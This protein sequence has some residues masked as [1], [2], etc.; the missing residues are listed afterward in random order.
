MPNMKWWQWLIRLLLVLTIVLI[1][2]SVCFPSDNRFIRGIP[3]PVAVGFMT[4]LG[5]DW[6][7]NVY[8]FTLGTLANLVFWSVVLALDII[9]RN[10][11]HRTLPVTIIVLLG[12]ASLGIGILLTE[13]SIAIPLNL[14]GNVITGF[15]IPIRIV[16]ANTNQTVY[17]WAIVLDIVFWSNGVLMIARKIRSKYQ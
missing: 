3:F 12:F 10:Y 6:E 4:I 5:V 8:W 17:V 7:T 14:W 1:T 15:P 16:N 13:L 9:F 2:S 11:I